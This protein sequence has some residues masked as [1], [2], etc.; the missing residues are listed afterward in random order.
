LLVIVFFTGSPVDA[1]SDGASAA[2][3]SAEGA[4]VSVVL[5][6]GADGVS[7]GGVSAATT[8]AGVDVISS[9]TGVD[10]VCSGTELD[11]WNVERER[12]AKDRGGATVVGEKELVV[13]SRSA[14]IRDF[15]FYL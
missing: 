1:A 11:S 14:A 15:I 6:A 9:G 13:D 3:G 2:A 8:A 7:S 10:S 5:A 4:V 12:V